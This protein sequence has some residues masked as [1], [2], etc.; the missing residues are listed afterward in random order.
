MPFGLENNNSR[1]ILV[2]SDE[3]FDEIAT[4]NVLEIYYKSNKCK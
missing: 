1:R 2:I 4:S 3:L